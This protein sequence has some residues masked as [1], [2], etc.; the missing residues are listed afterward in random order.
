MAY[1]IFT[2]QITMISEIF[3]LSAYIRLD[4]ISRLQST[5]QHSLPHLLRSGLGRCLIQ[6]HLDCHYCL[7]PS[8][9]NAEEDQ[10]EEER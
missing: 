5:S 9:S 2:M 8:R 7:L 10:V 3:S 6:L 1:L 4:K